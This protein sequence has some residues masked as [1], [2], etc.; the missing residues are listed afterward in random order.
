[1]FAAH[2]DEAGQIALPAL[3]RGVYEVSCP[4]VAAAFRLDLRSS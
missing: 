3:E 4:G 2:T 1:V